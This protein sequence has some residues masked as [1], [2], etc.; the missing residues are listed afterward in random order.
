MPKGGVIVRSRGTRLDLKV[1]T[2]LLARFHRRLEGG[3]TLQGLVPDCSGQDS[4]YRCSDV[5]TIG[6]EAKATAGRQQP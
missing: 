6:I 2:I 5:S 4:R 3:C 1:K